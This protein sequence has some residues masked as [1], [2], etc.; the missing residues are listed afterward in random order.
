MAAAVQAACHPACC[1]C[2]GFGRRLQVDFVL[3][4]MWYALGECDIVV[5]LRCSFPA[6]CCA[7]E[8]LDQVLLD[9]EAW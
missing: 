6:P 7:G 2:L 5:W 4:G 9:V 3:A 1:V 8:G